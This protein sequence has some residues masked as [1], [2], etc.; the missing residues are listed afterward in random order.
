MYLS[1]TSLLVYNLWACSRLPICSG[2]LHTELMWEEV[3][4]SMMNCFKTDPIISRPVPGSGCKR[5]KVLVLNPVSAANLTLLI[6]SV[7]VCEHSGPNCLPSK[8]TVRN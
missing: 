8:Y 6:G 5:H 1:I 4:S 2:A 3:V 7:V